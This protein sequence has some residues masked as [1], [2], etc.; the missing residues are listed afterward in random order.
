MCRADC[1]PS[2]ASNLA[3]TT[4]VLINLDCM[5]PGSNNVP[6]LYNW[7]GLHSLGCT[8]SGSVWTIHPPGLMFLYTTGSNNPDSTPTQSHV[9]GLHTT[10]SHKCGLYTT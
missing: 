9:S 5:P 3:H 2:D 7:T 8:P 4:P 1:T 6:S 10:W